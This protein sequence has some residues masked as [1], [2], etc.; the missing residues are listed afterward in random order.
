MTAGWMLLWFKAFVTTVLVETPYYALFLHGQVGGVWWAALVS[1]GLQMTTHPVLWL[2]W[3]HVQRLVSYPVLIVVAET[4]V[5]LAEAGLIML[6]IGRARWRRALLAS[7]VA[8]A[9][10]T[11]VG[12]LQ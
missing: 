12:L 11:L 9:A 8:N 1:L 4:L 6:V 3:P 7:L 2:V 5:V 10:S